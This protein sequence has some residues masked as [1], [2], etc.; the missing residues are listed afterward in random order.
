MSDV[1]RIREY[2]KF[3][4]AELQFAIENRDATAIG[5]GGMMNLQ[6]EVEAAGGF[7]HELER[8]A[9]WLEAGAGE[10]QPPLTEAEKVFYREAIKRGLEPG[11]EIR[12]QL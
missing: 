12:D 10:Y 9:E 4:R 6:R 2:V 7:L 3:R 5:G 11:K 8:F 1:E